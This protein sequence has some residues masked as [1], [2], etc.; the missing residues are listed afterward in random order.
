M[1][2]EV[3]VIGLKSI[4]ETKQNFAVNANDVSFVKIEQILGVLPFPEI[5]MRVERIYYHFEKIVPVLEG[6]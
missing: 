6:A 4:D 2:S 5:K 3:E 1:D